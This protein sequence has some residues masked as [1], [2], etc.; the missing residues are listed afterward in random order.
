VQQRTLVL[1]HLAEITAVDPTA[2]G[3]AVDEVLGLIR[4]RLED[5]YG[6]A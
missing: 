2:T 1:E 3:R 5:R 6:G 4:R